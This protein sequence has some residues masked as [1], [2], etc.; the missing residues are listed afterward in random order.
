MSPLLP[1]MMIIQNSC[2]C[3]IKMD[4]VIV[5]FV[6]FSRNPWIHW[7]FYSMYE[8]EQQ[9]KACDMNWV[10][11]PSTIILALLTACNK[12]S[13][14]SN[15]SPV[16]GLWCSDS[17]FDIFLFL[18]VLFWIRHEGWTFHD[19]IRNYPIDKSKLCWKWNFQG[20]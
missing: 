8:K 2:T 1:L 11:W 9:E 4:M 18:L 14:K 12:C 13:N 10:H 15:I 16:K 6:W 3:H 20:H 17:L 5:Q 7:P 19:H